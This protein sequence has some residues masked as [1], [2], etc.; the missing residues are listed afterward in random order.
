MAESPLSDTLS[1]DGCVGTFACAGSAGCD[2]LCGATTTHVK[3]LV[4]FSNRCVAAVVGGVG[5]YH[6]RTDAAMDSAT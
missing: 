3:V 5:V 4:L 2:E 1:W 6:V